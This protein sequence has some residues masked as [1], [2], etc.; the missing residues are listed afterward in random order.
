VR[1]LSLLVA[2]AMGVLFAVVGVPASALAAAGEISGQVVDSSSSGLDGLT[3]ILDD[4][5]DPPAYQTTTTSGGGFFSFSP[6][7]DGDYDVVVLG[8]SDHLDFDSGPIS[9]DSG[10][11]TSGDLGQIVLDEG[12][13]ITGIVRDAANGSP[14]EGVVVAAI[15]ATT[16]LPYPALPPTDATGL[17][18][19]AVPP[20]DDYYLI[21]LDGTLFSSTPGIAYD[22]QV[23]DHVNFS[24]LVTSCGCAFGD[25]VTVTAAWPG[26]AVTDIDFD[27][28][29]YSDWIYFSVFAER[30]PAPATEYPGLRIILDKWDPVASAWVL[31][32]A[33]DVT[34]AGGYA[35][36]FGYGAGDYRV[37]YTFG[38]VA[39][40]VVSYDDYSGGPYPLYDGGRSVEFP[41]LY[42]S[43][44]GC[45]CGSS[46]FETQDLDLLF[47][48]TSGGGGGGTPTPPRPP[49]TPNPFG[50][51][52]VVAPTATPTPTP[53]PT[54]APTPSASP[55]AQ[56]SASPTP[57]IA[58]EPV[59][60]TGFPWW[61]VLI[62]VLL[63]AGV[64]LVV[65]LIRRR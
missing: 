52:G 55:T 20:D 56:P 32:V 27:L 3:V 45:G 22:P 7:S 9:L 59:G 35:D 64:V 38:G 62:I 16:S 34:D 48:A 6:G 10:V 1:P 39:R 33:S 58:P 12:R 25:P 21:A 18:S 53:T 2:V 49:G 28:L 54:S 42:P 15:S 50:T 46:G 5:S 29:S 47:P 43:S 44:G 4:G 60:D 65:V 41:T 51:A 61:I 23:W 36:L 40:A 11:A 26:A 31:D 19:L 37:R 30:L 13:R 17:Y 63:V 14:L 57:T 8:G 24:T